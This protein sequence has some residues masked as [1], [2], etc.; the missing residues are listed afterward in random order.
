MEFYDN[1]LNNYKKI[2]ELADDFIIPRLVENKKDQISSSLIISKKDAMHE[3]KICTSKTSMWQPGFIVN[4]FRLKLD[5]ENANTLICL[6]D[7][8]K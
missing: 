7:W 5:P 1:K 4:K 3:C 6:Q 8:L 2:T